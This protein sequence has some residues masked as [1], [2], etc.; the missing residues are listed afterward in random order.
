MSEWKPIETAPQ[1]GTEIL[2]CF[3]HPD[4]PHLYKPTTVM[5]AAYHPNAEGKK[6]FRT[7]HIGG[8]KME[9]LTHWIPL[10]EPPKDI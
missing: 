2:A 1:D 9:R 7:S 6:T 3:W 8:N 10:P 4:L 5:W